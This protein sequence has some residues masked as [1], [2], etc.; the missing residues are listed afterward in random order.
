MS[1]EKKPKKEEKKVNK[2]ETK[3]KPET[4]QGAEKTIKGADQQ[5]K[6]STAEKSVEPSS[7]KSNTIN[8]SASQT[9]ISHFSSVS[10][11]EYRSGWEAIF[12][13]GKVTKKKNASSLN[14]VNLPIHIE[15]RDHDIKEDLRILLYK[16]LKSQARKNGISLAKCKKLGVIK[17]NIDCNVSEK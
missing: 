9:S 14:K 13:S 15:I 10:S 11:N 17:Y 2:T 5:S 4:S 16:A 8:K 7:E 3:S 1:E 6:E 12:G